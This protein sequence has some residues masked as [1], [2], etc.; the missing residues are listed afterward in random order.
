MFPTDIEAGVMECDSIQDCPLLPFSNLIW[1]DLSKH[2]LQRK[3]GRSTK[4]S[5]DYPFS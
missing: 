3:A 2:L 1:Q 5:K 4:I